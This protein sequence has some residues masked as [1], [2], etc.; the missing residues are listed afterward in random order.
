MN[1]DDA[2]PADERPFF[3]VRYKYKT[4]ITQAGLFFTTDTLTRSFGQEL[5]RVSRCR[6]QYMANRRCRHAED[7]PIR[8]GTERS[9]RSG[10]TRPIQ[11][12]TDSVYQVSRLG[13]FPSEAEAQ[14]VFLM[15]PWTPPTIRSRRTSSRAARAGTGS[16]RLSCPMGSTDADFMLQS[17]AIDNPSETTVVRFRPK[18]ETGESAVVPSLPDEPYAVSLASSQRSRESTGWSNGDRPVG[19]HCQAGR[20]KPGWPFSSS[21]RRRTA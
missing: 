17:T 13:F 16:R 11:A 12:D 18:G 4:P 3:A 21:L 14:H 5:L 7:S 6:G 9:P 19:R 15:P 20:R 8:T 2:F 10:S 1:A